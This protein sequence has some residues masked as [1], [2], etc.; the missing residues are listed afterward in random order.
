[1]K[2]MERISV[3]TLEAIFKASPPAERRLEFEV[4]DGEKITVDVRT[5][6]PLPD[7]AAFVNEVVNE[8]FDED[9]NYYPEYRDYMIRRQVLAYYGGFTMPKDHKKA[10]Q[11]V[12]GTPVYDRIIEVIDS[13]QFYAL[14]DAVMDKIQHRREIL[15]SGE[16]QVLMK[17]VSK[18]DEVSASIASLTE[19]VDM[20]AF[21]A[22]VGGLGDTFGTMSREQI[23]HELVEA[24]TKRRAEEA[25]KNVG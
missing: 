9:G 17:A 24:V 3:N 5:L 21:M 4:E 1:M 14:I 10:Y 22:A 20:E 18:M 13:K 23:V 7:T 15:L 2:K 8:C 19:G 25:E 16:R 6:L 11:F 12:Y